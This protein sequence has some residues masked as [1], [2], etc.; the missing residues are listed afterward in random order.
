MSEERTRLVIRDATAMSGAERAACEALW[1]RVWPP[2]PNKLEEH[3]PER[4]GMMVAY[5]MLLTKDG[6]LLGVCAMEEREIT[7]NGAPHRIAALGGVAVDEAHRQQGHGSRL[8][9]GSMEDARQRGY[10]FGVLWTGEQRV[11]FYER[12]GWVLLEGDL[13]YRWLGEERCI[14]SPI[15]A[16]AFTPVA[17]Q[18]LPAWR[19]GK[20]HLGVGGW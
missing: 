6:A 19:S 2:D 10:G 8:V 9:R 7:A 1:G 11:G 17:E 15:L 3:D 4:S 16:A 14:D 12:L 13:R 5:T 18:Q 20:L